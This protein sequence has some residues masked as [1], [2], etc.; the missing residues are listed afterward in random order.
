MR[1]KV[2]KEKCYMIENQVIDGEESSLKITIDMLIDVPSFSGLKSLPSPSPSSH[3]KKLTME[4]SSLE[5][6]PPDF[7]HFQLEEVNFN[8]NKGEE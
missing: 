3:L 5:S 7:F 2:R 4:K 1:T 8:E 6:L